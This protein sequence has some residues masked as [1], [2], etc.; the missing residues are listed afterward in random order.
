[1]RIEIDRDV[2]FGS[3]E[4]VL[5]APDVFELDATGLSRIHGSMTLIDLQTARRI[6]ADCPSGAISV[7]EELPSEIQD[8]EEV[9]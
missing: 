5:A 3:G 7:H 8:R 2:C 9:T 4:C 6:E 1:V